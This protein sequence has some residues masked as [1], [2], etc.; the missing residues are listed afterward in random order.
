MV[1]MSN[2]ILIAGVGNP[3]RQD[4]AFGI[5]LINVLMKENSFP[6]EV[7]MQEVGIGG[8]HLVQELHVGYQALILLDAVD[9]NLEPG[10]VSLRVVDK[11][12]HVEDLPKAEKRDFLADMHYTNPV[13]AMMLARSLNVL[14]RKVY[15][16]GCQ[17]KDTSDFAIGMS[18][19]VTLAIP[20]AVEM[21]TD[22]VNTY[23]ESHNIEV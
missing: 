5:E 15:I 4:D 8:I 16:L 21:L 14:P 17:A 19:E 12:Q 11:V 20:T 2:K 1:D 3:L 23:V 6:K 10:T 7:V 9:W 22:W 13:R 18:R